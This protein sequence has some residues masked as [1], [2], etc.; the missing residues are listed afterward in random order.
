MP[1]K[2]RLAQHGIRFGTLGAVNDLAVAFPVVDGQ[3]DP[4]AHTAS[5]SIGFYAS[6]AAGVEKI[7]VVVMGSEVLGIGADRVAFGRRLDVV[8]SAAASAGLRLAAGDDPSAPVVGDVWYR[9]ASIN[10]VRFF[11]GTNTVSVSAQVQ[12]RVVVLRG[13]VQAGVVT[14]AQAINFASPVSGTIVGWRI[15]TDVATTA[16]LDVWKLN[17]ANPTVANTIVA[18]APPAITAAT[19]AAS[20]TLTGWTT[21]IAAGDVFELN[22]SSNSAAKVVTLELDV[23]V[24]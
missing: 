12:K 23:V 10:A 19:Y 5:G 16:S 21:A 14:G 24:D 11:D 4:G 18:A 1:A 6:R 13:Q 15:V 20:T 22:V 7:G 9:G 8:A 3:D 17:G 2:S